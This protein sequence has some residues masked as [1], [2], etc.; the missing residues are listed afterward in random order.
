MAT[1][2][3]HGETVGIDGGPSVEQ[4]TG[5][6]RDGLNIDVPAVDAD[7]ID[8]G[9]LDSLALVELV[10]QLEQRFEIELPLDELDI[11][12]FRTVGQIASLIENRRRR[13]GG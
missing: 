13:G 1:V 10:F 12:N 8:G 4:V 11:E 9:F 3:Q 7:L 2:D 6:F 5:I